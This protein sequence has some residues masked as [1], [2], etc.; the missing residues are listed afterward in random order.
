MALRFVCLIVWMISGASSDVKALDSARFQHIKP[1]ERQIFVGPALRQRTT[2][3]QFTNVLNK[4]WIRYIP[5]NSYGVGLRLTIFGVGMEWSY[6]VPFARRNVERFGTSAVRDFQFNSFTSKW[7]ADFYVQRYS[8][9]YSKRSWA[10]L[11]S[12]DV[13]PQRDDLGLRTWGLSFTYLFNNGRYS[14]RAPYQFSEHQ[15][16]S[17]GSFMFGL[18]VNRFFV[19]GNGTIILQADQPYFS[20]EF[21]ATTAQFV[22]AA[23]TAGY[24]YTLVHRHYF[25]NFTA[26]AGP[27]HHWMQY[28]SSAGMHYDIYVNLYASY[29]AAIGYNGDRSFIG[30]TYQSK[31]AQGHILST[32][33][34]NNVSTFRLVAGIRFHEKG[35]LRLRPRNAFPFMQ[36]K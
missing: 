13:H 5:N 26:L 9:F 23:L 28:E 21:K 20:P 27:A 24:G 17:S 15:L 22:T 2:L 1:F 10:P 19:S 29:A 16:K 7:F 11:T 12:K 4:N 25:I 33:V 18:A 31:N 36:K 3:F 35:F 34:S 14:M 30:V 32:S 6:A 8:G